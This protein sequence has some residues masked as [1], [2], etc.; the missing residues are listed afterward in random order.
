MGGEGTPK[1]VPSAPAQ[2]VP[3]R[4]RWEGRE[5]GWGACPLSS[6]PPLPVSPPPSLP[7]LSPLPL[8]LPPPHLS[9][10]TQLSLFYVLTMGICYFH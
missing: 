2:V 8:L 4:G 10:S 3:L 5:V 9:L 6:L 1:D 7:P